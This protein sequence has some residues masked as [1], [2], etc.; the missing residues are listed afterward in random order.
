MTTN[1]NPLL[2]LENLT[3]SFAPGRRHAGPS[4]GPERFEA[5]RAVSLSVA[6]RE[7]HALVGESG[8]GKS[9]TA[10]A[11][12]GLLPAAARLDAGS[13][14]YRGRELTALPREELRALRGAEIGMVFQDPGR[15]LNPSMRV[16]RQI[17]ETLEEHLGM[18]RAAAKRRALELLEVV[19]LAGTHRVLRSYPH[20]LSGGMKQ[21]ALIAMAISCNPGLL[22]ADEP[23]TALDATVQGQILDLL[24]RLRDELSMGLL[25]VSHDFGVVQAIADRVSVIYAGELVESA[26]AQILFS[27]PLHPYTDL[28]ISAIPEA[29]KRGGRL[30]SVPGRPPLGGDVPSGCP[31]HPRCPRAREV[32]SLVG[33]PLVEHERGHS[34]ACHFPGPEASYG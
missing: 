4:P 11:V 31:F 3:V 2:C 10:R 19:E 5:V 26:P 22:I 32:C 16:G 23:T 25:F 17:A 18:P 13:V 24:R 15:Y 12:P 29:E 7:I 28:L 33:P 6:E 30:R 9:V 21:R 14:S 1:G 27:R 20:E 8:A 34:V